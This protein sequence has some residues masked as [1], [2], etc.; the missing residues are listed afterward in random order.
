MEKAARLLG[1]RPRYTALETV[2]EAVDR[3]VENGE[4]VLTGRTAS[5]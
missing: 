3:L 2:L 4:I 1:F 5:G